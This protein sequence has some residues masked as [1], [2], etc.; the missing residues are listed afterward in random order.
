MLH[1]VTHFKE[2]VASGKV[3]QICITKVGDTFRGVFGLV[4]IQAAF[5]GA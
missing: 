4:G 2:L 5:D 3:N 1:C